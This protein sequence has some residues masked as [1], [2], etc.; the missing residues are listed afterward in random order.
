[1]PAFQSAHGHHRG[2][3]TGLASV[4]SS[5]IAA[6]T[7]S[8][9]PVIVELGGSAP[10]RVGFR[11]DGRGTG[12]FWWSARANSARPIFETPGQVSLLGHLVQLGAGLRRGRTDAFALRHGGG[13]LTES[14]P[15]RLGHVRDRSFAPRAC[16]RF[17]DVALGGRA[18]LRTSHSWGVPGGA[19]LYSVPG[20]AS[21]RVDA[22][23][24]L[25]IAHQMFTTIGAHAFA[26]RAARE[27]D[28]T[29][30]SATASR[31]STTSPAGKPDRSAGPQRTPQRRGRSR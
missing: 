26:E 30:P 23:E 8:L 25:R 7:E 18:L 1:M 16:L 31:R 19:T 21:G 4:V 6:R 9:R 27:L 2:H 12:H 10:C 5:A 13:L 15:A 17:G 29:R 28:A 24:Q 11:L 20:C 3:A 14:S 22:R